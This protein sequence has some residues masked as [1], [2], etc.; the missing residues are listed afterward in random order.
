M[1]WGVGEDVDMRS[2]VE[3][4]G[5]SRG[6]GLD[7]EEINPFHMTEKES[8]N[9]FQTGITK[10]SV[11]LLTKKRPEINCPKISTDIRRLWYVIHHR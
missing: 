10:L 9:S 5:I 6:L 4:K 7:H 3:W 8:S 11:S 1:V 2:E